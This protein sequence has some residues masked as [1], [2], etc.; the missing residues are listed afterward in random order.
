[1]PVWGIEIAH[2]D[3]AADVRTP[4]Q[5]RAQLGQEDVAVDAIDLGPGKPGVD[6]TH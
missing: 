1:M 5:R 6:R 3:L 4:V 2:Q